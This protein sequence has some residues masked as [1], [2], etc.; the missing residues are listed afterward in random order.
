MATLAHPA[1]AIAPFDVSDIALYVDDTWREP[2]ARLRAEMPV[3]W[4][5]D[6]PYGGY[7]SVVSHALVG[8]VELRAGEFS[9]AA[10]N[11]NITILDP[12]PETNLENFIAMDAPRHTEQRKVVAPAFSPSQMAERE[13]EVRER[14]RELFDA[15]P[16]GETFDWVER[17]SVPLTVGM[18]CILFGF[19]WD[20]RH[21]LKLWSDLASDVKPGHDEARRAEFL[22]EMARML[23]RFDALMEERR[24]RPPSDDLLSRMVHS[25]AMGDLSPF[26]RISNL[27]LLIVGG[28]DTTRNSMSGLVEALASYPQELDKLRGDASLIPNAAQEIIR[29]QSPVTHM[30]RTAMADAELGGQRIAQGDKVVMWY[31]SANRDDAVFADAERFD[32]ARANARRHLAF[33]HGVHR[34]VG[35]RL[36]EIQLATLIGEIVARNWRIVPQGAPQRLPSPFLHGFLQMPVRIEA[37]G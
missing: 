13:V 21:D 16:V 24:R 35:A 22:G 3:S 12:P 9:S 14:T 4:C 5:P 29:W 30:R 19:P 25:E 33:G 6:S 23:G 10:A 28:N 31:I 1:R 17:V 20:E 34:C 37:R 2:F 11:G 26:E 18:L 32:V 15:L 7:W 8:E 36:A 27:A